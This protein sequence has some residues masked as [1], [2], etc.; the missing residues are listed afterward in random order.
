MEFELSKEENIVLE[1]S[2]F[3]SS[4]K[5]TL[6]NKRLVFQRK[7]GMFTAYWFAEK[8]YLLDVIE[9]AYTDRGSVTGATRLFMKLKNGDIV[10][11]P[12]A[13]GGAESFGSLGAGDWVTDT[14]V[15]QNAVNNRWVNAINNQLRKNQIKQLDITKKCSSCK[16]EI[17]QG[18]FKFCP[19]CGS[20]I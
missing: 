7:K 12:I 5:I 19:F 11:L 8:E 17:P 20:S 14:A 15:K 6:T 10:N 9:E 4:R 13:L 3:G 18:N 2:H 16:E 1:D